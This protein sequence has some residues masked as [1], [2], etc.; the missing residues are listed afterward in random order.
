VTT[1]DLSSPAVCSDEVSE[2]RRERAFAFG[3]LLIGLAVFAAA[4]ALNPYD[5]NGLARSHGTHHQL[6]LPPCFFRISTG[7]GCPSCGMTTSISLLMHGDFLSAW[8]ANAA[9]CFVA[10][11]GLAG[12]A[13]F[14]AVAAGLPPG[15]FTADEV[16]K[17]MAALGMSAAGARWIGSIVTAIAER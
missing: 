8:R 9:G 12:L 10:A 13:W 16:V 3:F 4:F 1:D 6:G 2:G 14:G 17:G 11:I 15:R 5:E 7:I